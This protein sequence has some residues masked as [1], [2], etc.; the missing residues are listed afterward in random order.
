MMTEK[1]EKKNFFLKKKFKNQTRKK[2]WINQTKKFQFSFGFYC[3]SS[4]PG[5]NP[6][7]S[8]LSYYP[9]LSKPNDEELPKKNQTRNKTAPQ[10]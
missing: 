4:L 8:I 7:V 9:S 6:K 3:L 10:L 1:C 2:K 5:P